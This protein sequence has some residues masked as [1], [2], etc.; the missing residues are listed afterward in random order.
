MSHLTTVDLFSLFN[1]P[2]PDHPLSTVELPPSLPKLH[3]ALYRDVSNGQSIRESIIKAIMPLSCIVDARL[4]LDVC[5][6]QLACARALL[7]Q[8]Q[9]TMKT[10]SLYSEVLFNM[11]PSSNISD[12]LKQFGVSDST[13]SLILLF[14]GDDLPSAQDL[15]VADSK[16][17]G[18]QVPI[19]EMD[20]CC[21]MKL[22]Q[23][24]F[25]LSDSQLSREI[26]LKNLINA[27]ALKG[28]T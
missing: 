11:S 24:I 6:I 21:D 23:K 8:Q 15:R 13:K 3:L 16:I 17:Q 18:R 27:M 26:A 22:L 10:R 5:Q 20:Q 7:A 14:V 28:Y 1:P 12:S 25:K 9:D 4:V 2:G 19:S